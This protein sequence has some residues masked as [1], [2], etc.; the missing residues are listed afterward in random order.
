MRALLPIALLALAA[1]SQS[2]DQ[3]SADDFA[4]RIG[5][6]EIDPSQADPNAPNTA[7]KSPPPGAN[8][9]QLQQLGDVA[10]VN[11]GPRQGGCT[12]MVGSQEMIIAAGMNEATLPGK[13]VVRVGNTLVMMDA[14]PGGLE[15]IKNGTKFEGEGF[16]LAMSVAAGAGQSRNANVVMRDAAGNTSQYSGK[17]ICA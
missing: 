16:S 5:S 13:A 9:T 8:L 12:F 2:N 14:G 11:L 4:S 1:C 17:W 7:V 10:G 3:E 15:G 6:G